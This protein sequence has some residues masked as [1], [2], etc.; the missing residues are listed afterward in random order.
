MT[1]TGFI[2]RQSTI[3]TRRKGLIDKCCM[4]VH[5]RFRAAKLVFVVDSDGIAG[6]QCIQ[7]F[8]KAQA[9]RERVYLEITAK[10]VFVI[11]FRCAKGR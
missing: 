3:M 4:A 5:V 2:N 1:T 11:G 9:N 6:L 7:P 10:M 8:G